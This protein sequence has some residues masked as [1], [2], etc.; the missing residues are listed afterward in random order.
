MEHGKIRF[1]LSFALF[2]LSVCMGLPALMPDRVTLFAFVI[3]MLAT[4]CNPA[5]KRSNHSRTVQLLADGARYIGLA[6]PERKGNR[7][8]LLPPT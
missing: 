2:S 5:S 6:A 4:R 8:F 1:V 3:A 7:H